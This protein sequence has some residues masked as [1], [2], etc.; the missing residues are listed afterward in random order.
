MDID[1]AF[2][3]RTEGTVLPLETTPL[4]ATVVIDNEATAKRIAEGLQPLGLS[5][6]T[7]GSRT[8]TGAV[9]YAVAWR[10]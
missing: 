2:G 6:F 10:N 1:T 9:G 8:G 7:D 5:I 4:Q 3:A